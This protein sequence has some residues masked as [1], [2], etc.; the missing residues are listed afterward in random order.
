VGNGRDG[1]A[2]TQLTVPLR[3]ESA[4]LGMFVIWRREVQPFSE[5]EVALL[6]N[7]AAQAVIAMENARLITE[8]RE[9][10]EHQTATAEVLRVINSSPGDLAPVF[11][12]MIERATR[13]CEADLGTLWT[14]DGDRFHPAAGRGYGDLGPGSAFEG[15][16]PTPKVPLGRL[17]AGESIV[18]VIDAASDPAFQ[19]DDVARTRTAIAGTRSSLTVA[20]RKDD[21]LLGA[22]TTGRK[23]VQPY[24]DQQI[25]LLQNFAAQAVIAIENARLLNEL[26]GRTR[27]LQESLEYQ[28]ATSD[29]LNVI[30]RST[31]DLQQVLETVSETAAR[32]CQAEVRVI[33]RRDGEVY[34][35]AAMAALSTADVTA[36]RRHH[37]FVEPHPL[38]PGRG[39]VT[40]RVALEGR[41][42]HII[43]CASDPEYTLTE[44]VR[45]GK[46]RTQLGVPLM[47]EG[48]P[49]GVMALSRQRVEPFTDKQIELVTTFANQAVIAIENA[50]LLNE[51]RDRTRDLQESLEYQTA[52]SDVLKVISGST[53]D[54]Q[55]VLDTVVETAARL[56]DAEMAVIL[57]RDGEVYRA[58]AAVGFPPEYQV[59]MEAQPIT[60]GLGT[61]TGR[62]ALEGRTVQIAD[63][64]ADPDYTLTEATT[65]GQQRTA[66]GVPLMREDVP[67]G[68][69]V[70]ARTRVELF[71][72]KQI[73][74]VRTF[75]DQAVI[76][77]ENTRLITETH[78][79]LEQQTA[80]AEVLQVINRSPGDL[81]PV[82]EAM[83]EKAM[84]LSE[85]AFG[86]LAIY[87]YGTFRTAATRGMPAAFVEYRRRSPP[88]Y[89]PGTQP[90]RLLAGERIIHVPDLMAED[91]YKTGD[92]NR[93][94]LVDLGGVRSSLM[95]PLLRDDAVLG[96]INIY[97]QE[98]R[99][100]SD[101]QIALLQSFAAQAVI[102]MDNARLLDEIRQRQAEL[103]VTFDNMG[104]GVAMFDAEHRLAA[105][106][107]NFQRI[108]DLPD[109]L[110][111]E[112]PSYAEYIHILAEY[113]PN[114]A[115]SAVTTSRRNSAAA[116]RRPSKNCAS[117][118]S[119]PT[120]G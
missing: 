68:V 22:I 105:W 118:A 34:R 24:S 64:A 58:A 103:R 36:F 11:D 27:D 41:A 13:L 17:V 23:R 88:D 102:A 45:L 117:N 69:I 19:S 53:F 90:A 8:T 14:F 12:A 59:F 109:A 72:E 114:V 74:L 75:A 15:V 1:G 71:T 100:F 55:P 79:A 80:T 52:T 3:K 4:L 38:T 78:E 47:R 5:K 76:A 81:A 107:L 39:S 101:K 21:V 70:L 28:T 48:S 7:F 110:V 29:V 77:I 44:A 20:L 54:L 60:P 93:R 46:I 104:D 62:V 49:I 32:L 6:Q 9:A 43:D 61:I 95:V 26:R 86:Q 108:L 99:P 67:I 42:V 120:G 96:F 89:G 111:A 31:F 94:A 87:E 106:N 40:G 119:G 83:L 97:R 10:L 30:S 82:F 57:R 91:I 65:I 66:L 116:L 92:P 18:H 112:R 16:R 115:N 37:E 113:L 63:V 98:P 50:R 56:C 25:A 33:L 51:L 73:E 35:P 2:R 85:A 84:R